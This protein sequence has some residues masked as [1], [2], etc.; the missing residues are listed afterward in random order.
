MS[1]RD[2][3]LELKRKLARE[4]MEYEGP[5]ESS[6]NTD[7]PVVD[8]PA[9]LENTETV[10]A[11]GVV[12][13]EDEISD[14]TAQEVVE[15]AE[16]EIEK[17]NEIIESDEEPSEKVVTEQLMVAKH[18]AYKA[19]FIDNIRNDSIAIERRQYLATESY[20]FLRKS[21]KEQLRE[22]NIS[23]EGIIDSI[24]RIFTGGFKNIENVSEIYNGINI[25][26][27]KL[28]HSDDDSNMMKGIKGFNVES[29][30]KCF[31][32]EAGSSFMSGLAR[33]YLLAG[34]YGGKGP[35]NAEEAMKAAVATFIGYMEKGQKGLI[36]KTANLVKIDAKNIAQEENVEEDSVAAAELNK[37][38]SKQMI[39]IAN[40]QVNNDKATDV[41]VLK[42]KFA[43]IGVMIDDLKQL[44]KAWDGIEKSMDQSDASKFAQKSFLDLCK[45]L[46]P[47]VKGVGVFVGKTK[48]FHN[49]G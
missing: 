6:E 35:K 31:T 10:P 4:A 21:S 20:D 30:A 15:E 22:A 34:Y 43:A 41:N 40:S 8:T 28:T 23:L 14:E 24:K 19:G 2:E 36:F 48:K 33:L 39:E 27:D 32:P 47:V 9:D 7:T 18:I 5:A 45:A 17:N 29:F 1:I 42:K 12:S 38:N 11:E 25:P 49:K 26:W 3:Y 46:Q 13:G 44:V 37:L 16:T